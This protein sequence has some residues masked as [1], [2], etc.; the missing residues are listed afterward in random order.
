MT[1][2][3]KGTPLSEL[4]PPKQNG[5]LWIKNLT[6]GIALIVIALGWWMAGPSHGGISSF[7]AFVLFGVGAAWI[8][9]GVLNRKYQSQNQ[10]PAPKDMTESVISPGVSTAEPLQ[11]A[12]E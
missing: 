6:V 2:I 5:S 4:R 9:R 11:Q 7:I 12:N 1:A 10:P 3:E 8:V